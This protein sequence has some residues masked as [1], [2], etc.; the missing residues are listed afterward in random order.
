MLVNLANRLLTLLNAVTN[1]QADGGAMSQAKSSLD[2]L[3]QVPNSDALLAV[4]G[5]CSCRVQWLP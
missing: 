1:M 3:L 4:P 5:T 2:H